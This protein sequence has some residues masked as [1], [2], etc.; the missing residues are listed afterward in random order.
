MTAP[1]TRLVLIRHG[2]S[3]AQVR[4]YLSGHD[5]CGGLSDGGREQAHALRDRLTATGELDQVDA[6][7]TSILSRAIETAEIIGP[8]LGDTVPRQ[9]CDWCEIHPG[10]AEGLTWDEFRARYPVEGDPGDPYRQRA[11]GAETWAEF[12]V[13]AGARLRRIADEHPGERVVVVCHG[14]IIGASFVALGD[15]PIRKGIALTHETVNTSMTEWRF[16]GSEWRL[17]RYNDAAH[18]AS[19]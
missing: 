4:G 13:R 7:Y 1:E 17:V 6:V 2:E 9:E 14:G 19:R 15:L 8:G 16:T 5:V 12:Y 18:L 3:D 10:E 11:P